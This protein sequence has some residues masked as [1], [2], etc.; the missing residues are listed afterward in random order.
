[1]TDFQKVIKYL[2]IAFAI[3]L[4]IGILGGVAAAL[5]AV[6]GLLN[7]EPAVGSMRTYSITETITKLD[8]A[9]NAA[10][11]TIEVGSGCEVRINLKRLSVEAEDG[12]LTI[13]DQQKGWQDYQDAALILTLPEG[14]V[15][16]EVEIETG[17]GRFSVEKLEAQKLSFEFGAGEVQIQAL[18]AYQEAQIHG[19]A[20]K[21]VIDQ[22]VLHDLELE[23]GAGGLEL[24]ARLEGNCDLDYGV[25]E[26]RLNLIGDPEAYRIAYS[27]GLGSFHID[28]QAMS[29]S[30]T[31]GTGPNRVD[32]NGGIGASYVSILSFTTTQ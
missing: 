16:D 21:I 18:Y 14:V 9:I 1:M 24:T 12:V 4:I 30:G 13:E 15:F 5:G 28:G 25:G 8:V 17:A 19:G 3:L 26:A 22:G 31:Y 23:M 20:G 32:I 2:A 10:D 27:K 29:G 11:F 7:R 6:F